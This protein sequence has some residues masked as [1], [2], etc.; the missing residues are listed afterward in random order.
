MKYVLILL[1]AGAVA[2]GLT[3]RE[4]SDSASSGEASSSEEAAREAPLS[5]EDAAPMPVGTDV[6]GDAPDAEAGRPRPGQAGHDAPGAPGSGAPS[7][8]GGANSD[9]PPVKPLLPIGPPAEP[10]PLA[11]APAEGKPMGAPDGR[12]DYR[13]GKNRVVVYRHPRLLMEYEPQDNEAGD[14]IPPVEGARLVEDVRPE[15]TLR[16]WELPPGDDAWEVI[17]RLQTEDPKRRLSPVYFSGPDGA[18]SRRA[19]PGGITVQFHKDWD[20][21]RIAEFCKKHGLTGRQPLPIGKGWYR[22]E[23]QAGEAALRLAA[24]IQATGE[25]VLAKPGWATRIVLK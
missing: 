2:W 23:S 21:A 24:R 9:K 13:E 5:G 8:P 6:P 20:E 3:L 11:E 1:A 10:P 4:S 15:L 14:P 17:T 12:I 22:F 25:V 7:P 18:G 16:Q 19:L